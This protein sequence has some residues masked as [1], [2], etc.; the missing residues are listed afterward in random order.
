MCFSST[1]GK[2]FQTRG[3]ATANDLSQSWT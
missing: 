3:L 2:K 1:A